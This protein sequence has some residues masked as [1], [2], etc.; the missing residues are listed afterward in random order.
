VL[1]QAL[2]E[3]EGTA[4]VVS[5]D[6]RFLDHFTNKILYVAD[7]TAVLEIGTYSDWAARRTAI[8]QAPSEQGVAKSSATSEA[9]SEWQARKVRRAQEQKLQRHRRRLEDEI[10]TLE[11]QVQSI[12]TELADDS[13]AH[14][15][16]R[17]ADL[18]AERGRL[19]DRLT[20]L[21]EELE[22]LPEHPDSD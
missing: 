4:L 14:D 18:S 5:H 15:W 9:A 12:E 10:A 13:I 20:G 17:L 6:R 2:A 8:E 19:Y 11:R 1:E 21:Y 22:G 3:F 7:A 16:E